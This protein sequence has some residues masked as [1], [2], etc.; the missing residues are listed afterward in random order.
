ML[1]VNINA[2]KT[3][4]FGLNVQIPKNILGKC[5]L[6]NNGSIHEKVSRYMQAGVW[7]KQ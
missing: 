6:M 7:N 5:K 1:Y 3:F 2:L 4:L